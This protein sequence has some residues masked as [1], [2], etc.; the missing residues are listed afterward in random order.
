M[1]ENRI[2]V[3]LVHA[4][5]ETT[6]YISA[7]LSL[8]RDVSLQ[9]TAATG[10]EG[11]KQVAEFKP[12]VVLVGSDLPDQNSAALVRQI[13]TQLPRTG[14]IALVESDDPEELRRY[15]QAGARSFLILPFSSE[16]LITSIREVHRRMQSVKVAPEPRP[17]ATPTGRE[18]KIVAIFSPKGGVGKSTLAVNLA[19][20]LRRG[21]ERLV[22]LLDASFSF[23][24]L[25]LFLNIK[26]DR[27]IVDFIERGAEGDLELLQQLVKRHSSGVAFL[28]R[29]VRPEHA[30]MVNSE[31]LRRVLELLTQAYDIV[32]LDCPASYDDRVLMVLDRADL[33][34]LVVTPDVGTLYNATAFLNLAKALGYARERI[35]VVVN[36][37]DS[38]GGVSV[39]EVED[40]LAHPVEHKIPSRW[41]D[42]CSALNTGVPVTVS[43][44]NS[45]LS[46]VMASVA[47]LV[48]K[49][50]DAK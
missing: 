46:R 41:R 29:P 27:S 14:V 42:L 34:L 38:Q 1:V 37:Y 36:R 16:Q 32:V 23:G 6:A 47:D 40:T 20:A 2:R 39:K 10:A 15:M 22:A 25:H 45:D 28:A 11:L 21:G 19:V 12:D 49:K 48:V 35:T 9:G 44:P 4:F 3:L 26:P 43:Q 24:D 7:L 17:V 13:V 5:P 50:L 33:I 8:E 18:G 30:E 31:N